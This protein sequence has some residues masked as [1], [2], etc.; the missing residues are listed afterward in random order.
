GSITP[1]K[2]TTGGD[3]LAKAQATLGP[4]GSYTFQ[5]A[6][7]GLVGSPVVFTSQHGP[8]TLTYTDPA[9]GA[10]KLRLVQDAKSTPT[11]AVLD[12]VVAGPDPLVGY[13][14][15]F[16]L[17][18][19]D[20]MVSLG[21]MTPGTALDP[22]SAPAAAKAVLPAGGVMRGVLVAAQS[23]KASGVGAVTDDT[24]LPA[25]TVIFTISLDLRDAAA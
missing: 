18:L 6:S 25:G 5:A 7:T 13:A 3:G 21:G 12:L 10:G 8:F 22:G 14:A 17:A 24:S 23:H 1:I 19:D 4:T 2:A 15:G 20:S 11:T 9:A 16:D